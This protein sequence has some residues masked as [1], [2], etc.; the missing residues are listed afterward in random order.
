MKKLIM[1]LAAL[2]MV[3][4][5][6]CAA[7]TILYTTEDTY[8]DSEFPATNLNSMP[9]LWAGHTL[10]NETGTWK[11]NATQNTYTYLKFDLSSLRGKEIQ[12]AALYLHNTQPDKQGDGSNYAERAKAFQYV[13]DIRVYRQ[14]SNWHE[15]TLT[16]NTANFNTSYP[17]DITSLVQC[18]V[19]DTSTWQW[20]SWNVTGFVD[21]ILNTSSNNLSLG[22]AAAGNDDYFHT[23]SSA[24][25]L[26]NPGYK[27][28][29]EVTFVPEP[30]SASLLLLGGGAL[31]LSRRKKR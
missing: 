10:S 19:N 22:L 20:Y 2:T 27:P 23:F 11:L 21:G 7:S 14:N 30:V 13:S 12:S 3:T 16:Y 28:Y 31:M 18:V 26:A 1:I 8:V 9:M 29:L 15:N 25:D 24:G 4:A 5:P 6:A 17:G